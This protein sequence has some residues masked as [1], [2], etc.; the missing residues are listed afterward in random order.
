MAKNEN[1]DKFMA[2]FLFEALTFDDVSLVT[3]YAD[4]LPEQADITTRI[5]EHIEGKSPYLS[6]AMDTVTESKTAIAIAMMGGIGVI[7]KNLNPE[8][9]AKEVARVKHHLHAKI[10]AP[11]HV[12]E[13]DTIQFIRDKKQKKGWEFDSF[14]VLNTDGN[15]VGILTETDFK[16]CRNYNLKAKDI[17]TS[18]PR[19]AGTDIT[20]E[21]AFDIMEKAGKKTTL[22]LVDK[23]GKLV[24]M[25]VLSDVKRILDK[26]SA[27]Y[28]ID[29]NNQL[30]V[31]AAVGPGKDVEE[32][33]EKLVAENIDIIVIDTAH[34]HSQGVI[35]AITYLKNFQKEYGFDIVAGNIATKEGAEALVKAGANAVKVGIG[36]GSICTT[37]IVAGVGIPQITAVYNVKQGAGEIPVIADGGIRH[38][39][40]VPKAILAGADTVMLGSILAGTDESPGE[41][42]TLEGRQYVTYRGMGS[43]GAMKER[44]AKER[45]NQGHIQNEDDLVPQGIEGLVPYAG[46]VEKVLHQFIGGLQAGMGYCGTRTIPLLQEK[47]IFVRVS[48]A[49][50]QEAHP[51]DVKIT[52]EAPNYKS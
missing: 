37:R 18:N 8:D 1:L 43:L 14:P 25:Y 12:L 26:S 19:T 17:M 3:Q 29:K 31:A 2:Q 28:N 42:I 38:S 30:R 34:G 50:M 11:I 33:L 6:A 27:M 32:R 35:D 51:H 22:P 48:P 4:F 46:S 47:G 21:Q 13:D 24:G 40:D 7:H 10:I 5:T 23:S 39:G 52:K 41:K 36:P 15:L 45:Y 44:G 49:G 9:Q 20:L 16:F